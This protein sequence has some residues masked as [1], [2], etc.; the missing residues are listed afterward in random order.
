MTTKI[1]VLKRTVRGFGEVDGRAGDVVDVV[2][3]D[4]MRSRFGLLKRP[5]TGRQPY[6]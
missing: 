1:R 3:E 2:G 4:V 6:G 5:T